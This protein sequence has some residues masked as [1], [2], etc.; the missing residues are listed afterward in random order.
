MLLALR[1]ARGK[2]RIFNL[3]TDEYC[4]VSDSIGWICEYLGRAPR[5][6]YGDGDRGWAGDNPFI[7]LDC[8]RIRALGW[9]PKLG[10]REAVLRTVRYLES[11]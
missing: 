2:V 1:E 10:I 3:G 9:R 7:L 4:R 5:I 8:S 11:G 6:S